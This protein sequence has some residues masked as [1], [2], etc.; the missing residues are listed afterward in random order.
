MFLVE[1]E[2]AKLNE[3]K[4]IRTLA[5]GRALGRVMTFPVTVGACDMA[6]GD[7]VSAVDCAISIFVGFNF[8]AYKRRVGTL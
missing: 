1:I 7:S 5:R 8:W 4:M 3:T 6:E 2:I